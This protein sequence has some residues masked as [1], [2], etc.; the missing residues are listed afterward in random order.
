MAIAE[1][2]SAWTPGALSAQMV[3][4]H[5]QPHQPAAP[6]GTGVQRLAAKK[7]TSLFPAPAPRVEAAA[8]AAA[9]VSAGAASLPSASSA[10]ADPSVL[11]DGK[12]RMRKPIGEMR[13]CRGR[14]KRS[15]SGCAGCDPRHAGPQAVP[16]KRR[17][18]LRNQPPRPRPHLLG[19]KHRP[20]ELHSVL[21]PVIFAEGRGLSG[22][23][24]C[25]VRCHIR[26]DAENS[27]EPPSR[28]WGLPGHARSNRVG[29]CKP[30]LNPAP[31]RSFQG[32]TVARRE[33]IVLCK[34]RNL[35]LLRGRSRRRRSDQAPAASHE[36]GS[37]FLYPHLLT[38]RLDPHGQ[39]RSPVWLPPLLLRGPACCPAKSLWRGNG[40]TLHGRQRL[41]SRSGCGAEQ[42]GESSATNGCNSG[43]VPLEPVSE[44]SRSRGARHIELNRAH[45]GDAEVEP[46]VGRQVRT[47]KTF[48]ESKRTGDANK[49]YPSVSLPAR[50]MLM[51]HL[52]AW[53]TRRGALGSQYQLDQIRTVHTHTQTRHLS[54]TALPHLHPSC[55]SSRRSRGSA[56]TGSGER[57]RMPIGVHS[58]AASAVAGARRWRCQ[59]P[60]GSAAI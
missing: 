55:R 43:D 30:C 11:H 54:T 9:G 40:R 60:E 59:V 16:W 42:H 27:P 7:T 53:A 49:T 52:P 20:L 58:A 25:G 33:Q 57:K 6:M 51:S 31:P 2:D 32:R 29:R 41:L 26:P 13:C 22:A 38:V 56:S 45:V 17:P 15:A 24:H 8:A 3:R 47:A 48:P 19:L 10:G 36:G 44:D 12:N 35:G 14:P 37:A 28:S 18:S 39:H 34:K 23:P 1:T 4:I 50:C 46:P 21:L 5:T